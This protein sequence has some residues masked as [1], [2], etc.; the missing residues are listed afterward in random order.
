MRFPHL[1]VCLMILGFV[2][3]EHATLLSTMSS[4]H[5]HLS[6]SSDNIAE[7]QDI[8][9]G[10]VNLV[11]FGHSEDEEADEDEEEK[12]RHGG[13]RFNWRF[14]REFDAQGFQAS[15]VGGTEYESGFK[16]NQDSDAVV[17]KDVAYGLDDH[18]ETSGDSRAT[19]ESAGV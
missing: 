13:G 14:K 19:E 8:P 2:I 17:I 12:Q 6:A 3:D 5:T 9:I 4:A 16:N 15:S 18:E 11:L 10:F 1:T 7:I